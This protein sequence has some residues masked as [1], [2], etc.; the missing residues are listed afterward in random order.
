VPSF[1]A[2][3]FRVACDRLREATARRE[4]KGG[5]LGK[6]PRRRAAAVEFIGRALRAGA[7]PVFV[8]AEKRFCVV[9]KMVEAFADP[10]Y[11]PAADWIPTGADDLRK[12]ICETLLHILP[13]RTL[14]AFSDAQRDPT[15]ASFL[16]VLESI[17]FACRFAGSDELEATFEGCIPHLPK[18]VEAERSVIV[19]SR[20]HAATAVNLFAF[21]AF[22]AQADELIEQ[23]LRAPVRVLHDESF[24]FEDAFRTVHNWFQGSSALYGPYLLQSGRAPRLGV[25]YLRDLR[26][27]PSKAVPELQGTDMLAAVLR[28]VARDAALGVRNDQYQPACGL[29]GAAFP[30]RARFNVIGSAAFVYTFTRAFAA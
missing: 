28:E 16:S 22:M 7:S 25:Q 9:A 23:G 4:A 12:S 27:A 17:A 29:L 5:T 26:M 6:H 14:E 30:R 18:V 21:V 20:R 3:G 13:H 2:R 24:E 10:F 8:V 15:V 11:N 19:G 1:T